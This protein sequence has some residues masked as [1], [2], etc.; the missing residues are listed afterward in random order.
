MGKISKKKELLFSFQK[1]TSWL[2]FNDSFLPIFKKIIIFR[3]AQLWNYVLFELRD[4]FSSG[5]YIA[6]E[7]EA[8]HRILVE[9]KRGDV[10]PKIIKASDK[11]LRTPE[12]FSVFQKLFYWR[13]P[14]FLKEI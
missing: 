3:R 14:G 13:D 8:P 1:K 10:R 9:K 6:V 5:E 4:T 11:V 2:S 7:K 12:E